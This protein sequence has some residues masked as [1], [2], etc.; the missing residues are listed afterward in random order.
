VTGYRSG[1]SNKG[2]DITF[3]VTAPAGLT[4]T[5]VVLVAVAFTA[6]PA[7]VVTPPTGFTLLTRL[8]D[9]GGLGLAVYWGLGSAGAP[10]TWTFDSAVNFMYDAAAFIGG[11]AQTPVDQYAGVTAASDTALTAQGLTPT[12]TAELLVTIH[13]ALVAGSITAPT[14]MVERLNT[15]DAGLGLSLAT[16]TLAWVPSTPSPTG[17]RTETANTAVLG[18]SVSI[19]LGGNLGV[20]EEVVDMVVEDAQDVLVYAV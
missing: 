15:T 13:A 12:E 20:L 7:K 3:T 8:D 16:N 14:G 10:W 4:A 19:L 11:D 2:A 6:G 9:A 17:Q 5:D 18:H 1:T